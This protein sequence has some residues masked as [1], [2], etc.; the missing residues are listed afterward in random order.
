MLRDV[1]DVAV[2]NF[3]RCGAGRSAYGRGP[4]FLILV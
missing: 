4:L 2:D 3:S 1:F